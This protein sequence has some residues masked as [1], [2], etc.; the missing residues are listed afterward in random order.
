MTADS[1]QSQRL[2]AKLILETK[3]TLY[4]KDTENKNV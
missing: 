2:E 1:S 3:H 4:S